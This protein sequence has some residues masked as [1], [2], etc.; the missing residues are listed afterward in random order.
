MPSKNQM[1]IKLASN[2]RRRTTASAHQSSE[3]WQRFGR[4]GA[5]GQL[6]PELSR[7][8]VGG[9]GRPWLVQLVVADPVQCR[10]QGKTVAVSREG[11]NDKTRTE[12]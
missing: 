5:G 8:A 11:S 10:A 1:D 4:V 3:E 6:S 7:S 2:P 9:G 12:W